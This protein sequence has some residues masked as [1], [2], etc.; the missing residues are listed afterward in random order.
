MV[1]VNTI[2]MFIAIDRS[3]S[4]YNS[5]FIFLAVYASMGRVPFFPACLDGSTTRE[6]RRGYDHR[7]L[8][9]AFLNLFTFTIV[10]LYRGAVTMY[11]FYIYKNLVYIATQVSV[12]GTPKQHFLVHAQLR[13]WEEFLRVVYGTMRFLII[14]SFLGGI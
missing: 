5:Q 12:F 3:F 7:Y 11:M 4:E 6:A 10:F 1:H 9:L 14:D 2:G 8:L 13:S